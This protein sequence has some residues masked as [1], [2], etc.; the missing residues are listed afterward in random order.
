[1]SAY[2][3]IVTE[4]K[5]LESLLKALADMGYKPEVAPDRKVN[6]LHLNGYQGDT[7]PELVVVRV[8]R[9]QISHWSNDI[10]FAWNGQVYEAVISEYDQSFQFRPERQGTLKQR[11]TLHETKRVASLQGYSLAESVLPDGTIQLICT[12]NGY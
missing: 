5:T 12:S 11:Y 1:M 9:N 10:G 2:K 6:S 7:R 8:P 3:K 4:F